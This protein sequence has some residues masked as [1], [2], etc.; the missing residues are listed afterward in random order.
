MKKLIA[1]AVD[2][3]FIV[4]AVAGT[5]AV[6]ANHAHARPAGAHPHAHAKAG[7]SSV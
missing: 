5:L 7:S 4:L 2:F 6:A 3:R 1:G